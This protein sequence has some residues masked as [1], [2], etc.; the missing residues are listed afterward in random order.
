MKERIIAII[1][2]IIKEN[3]VKRNERDYALLAEI[4]AALRVDLSNTLNE[5]YKD[6]EIIVG[7]TINDKWI[8][9]NN[10]N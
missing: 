8:K 7:D 1:A 10:S 5:M 9:I 6:K 2:T 3:E 4:K